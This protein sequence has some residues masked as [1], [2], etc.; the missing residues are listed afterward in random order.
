MCGFGI[1]EVEEVLVLIVHKAHCLRT[2]LDMYK[3]PFTLGHLITNIIVMCQ[4]THKLD[5]LT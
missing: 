4:A 3:I 1:R 5:Q 2:Q